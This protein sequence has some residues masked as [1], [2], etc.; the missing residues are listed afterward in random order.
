MFEI[1]I[2]SM[3]NLKVTEKLFFQPGLRFAFHSRFLSPISPT[4]NF[5]FEPN[6]IISTRFSY[7]RGY[8]N[9]EI[10]EMFFEFI[11]NNHNIKGNSDLKTEINDNFQFGFDIKPKF[12]PYSNHSYSTSFTFSYINKD[13][14]IEIVP[15]D[16]SKNE[17]K[18]FNI[19]TSNSLVFSLDNR[20]KYK[21]FIFA[22]GAN[23]LGNQKIYLGVKEQIRDF[24]YNFSVNLNTTYT[25]KASYI[26]FQSYEKTVSTG[27]SNLNYN[28]TLKEGTQLKELE[29]DPKL[30]TQF[31]NLGTVSRSRASPSQDLRLL[32]QRPKQLLPELPKRL[33][34]D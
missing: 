17:F 28:I 25:I 5:R 6:E 29:L 24:F 22:L 10:K 7:S 4:A 9:P 11:D 3:I 31:Q 14:A 23:V 1:G 16:I 8:R 15:V 32:T 12:K 20:M 27:A 2:F 30:E 26:G 13:K 21:N 34:S 19:G 18:Y 33:R